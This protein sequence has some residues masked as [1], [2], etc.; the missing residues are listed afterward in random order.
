MTVVLLAAGASSARARQ[1]GACPA[2]AGIPGFS[3]GDEAVNRCRL[4]NR[5]ALRTGLDGV[6]E[7]VHGIQVHSEMTVVVDTAGHVVPDFTRYWT[8]S[9]L[10]R[11]FHDA[12]RDAILAWRFDPGIFD[13]KPVRFGF[14]LH[15]VTGRRQDSIPSR[16]RWTYRSGGAAGDTLRGV[17]ERTSPPEP[18][19]SEGRASAVRSVVRTLVRMD[20]L[21]AAPQER[22]CLVYH[23][24]EPEV[25]AD[26]AR[27]ALEGGAGVVAATRTEG[28]CAED[29]RF[30]RL[31]LGDFV[32]SGG[33]RMVIQV[34]GDDLAAWP[35]GFDASPAR[36]WTAECSLP[37]TPA[38]DRAAMC[39]VLPVNPL[40]RRRGLDMAEVLQAR[41]DS[42]TTGAT[43]A[44]RVTFADAFRVDT[45]FGVL[46]RIPDLRREARYVPAPGTCPGSTPFAAEGPPT[47]RGALIVWLEPHVHPGD[48][49]EV[50]LVEVRAPRSDD[51]GSDRCVHPGT[52]PHPWFLFNLGGVGPPL[53]DSVTFCA[54]R[55]LCG[56]RFVV[57][58]R[59]HRPLTEPQLR[60]ST[61]DLRPGTV[62]GSGTIMIRLDLDR[63]PEGLIPFVV[64]RAGD[65]LSAHAFRR[66]GLGRYD[67]AVNFGGDE[68]T[69]AEYL[70]YFVT[71]GP[72]RPEP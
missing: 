15:V 49:A 20:V 19:S 54:H 48:R 39:F 50:R 1:A 61:S 42:T 14:R 13:G 67:Y 4:A 7:P 71:T 34:S 40:F 41:R 26:A 10:D 55:P 62:E 23:G 36:A 12:A 27:S 37:R 59:G 70:I 3:N 18:L 9:A 6:P 35:P 45:L 72:D 31:G 11:P 51:R 66:I 65:W 57:D 8:I 17:W 63:D 52:S 22:I 30:R 29:V 44:A 21:P 25:L 33:E 56:E 58:P 53:R 64:R 5:P 38:G 2:H 47:S 60:F 28:S 68:G 69:E 46:P 43:F 32:L 16:I 24:P